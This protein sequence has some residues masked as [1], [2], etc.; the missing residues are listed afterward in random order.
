MA[1]KNFWI[2]LIKS[3]NHNYLLLENFLNP[4]KCNL[5]FEFSNVSIRIINILVQKSKRFQK[6]GEFFITGHLLILKSGTGLIII[7][8]SNVVAS[9][10]LTLAPGNLIFRQAKEITAISTVAG[11][12]TFKV[13]GKV[14]PGCKNKVV[15]AGNSLTAICSYRPSNHS[16]VRIS[17]TLVPD[18]IYFSE[19]ITNSA[20]YLVTRR[21]GAR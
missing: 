2:K 17:A 18:D 14:I 19:L 21:T 3:I 13:A 8:Y 12:I 15:N 4:G 7:R 9:A 16:Y 11:K 20:L 5:S 6:S 1:F 10:S